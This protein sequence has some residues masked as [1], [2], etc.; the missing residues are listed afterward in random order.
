MRQGNL[1]TDSKATRAVLLQQEDYFFVDDVL[2]HLF[3]SHGPQSSKATAQ[4]V[5]PRNMRATLLELLNSVTII[6]SEVT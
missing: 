5:I 6:N 4:L 1:P 2:F 3:T